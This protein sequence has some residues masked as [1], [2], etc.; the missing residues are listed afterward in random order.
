[1]IRI[2]AILFLIFPVI[3]VY[4][5]LKAGQ[6]F[7]AINT[8]VA[9]ILISIIGAYLA[10][11]QGKQMLLLTQIEL[12]QGRI[13]SETILDG[14]AILIGG[15]LLLAPGFVTDIVGLLLLIPI[16]RGLLKLLMKKWFERQIYSGNINI[17]RKRW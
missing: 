12:Q 10:K 3:E 7:G 17:Y 11:T 8:I 2:L 13:P 1:M 9:L 4:F 16:T 6:I 5:I 14:L 15:I